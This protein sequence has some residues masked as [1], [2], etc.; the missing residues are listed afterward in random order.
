MNKLTEVLPYLLEASLCMLGFYVLYILLYRKQT[1]FKVNR[2]YL[3]VTLLASLVIPLIKIHPLLVAQVPPALI[4][5]VTAS[6]SSPI[7]EFN[8]VSTFNI[9]NVITII[10]LIGVGLGVLFYIYKLARLVSL[11]ASAKINIIGRYQV[12]LTE[13]KY[14]TSSF[15]NYILWDNKSGEFSELEMK[16][17]IAHEMVHIKQLHTV[18][19]LLVELVKCFF[20]FNPVA[21]L[22]NKELKMTHEFL[23][24]DDVVRKSKEFTMA[25][26]ERLLSKQLLNNVGYQLTNNFNMSN[27]KTRINMI[28]KPKSKKA[29]LL[30][31]FVAVPAMAFAILWVQEPVLA[32]NPNPVEIIN[33]QSIV[34]KGTYTGKKLYVQNPFKSDGSG[35]TTLEVR[36]NGEVFDTPSINSSAFEIDLS[37][38]YPAGT[39]V[40]IE[41]VHSKGSHPR[42]LNPEVIK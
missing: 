24:D 27:L 19:N 42:F 33:G 31:T 14:P 2:V 28:S 12:I 30:R 23:A 17:M 15:F 4:N 40:K 16:S 38:K 22:Y 29:A 41:L 25:D 7:I 10:Y 1:F 35:F 26:Y 11:I 34:L 6:S 18:D 39:D 13:G 20:W 9:W 21:Y 5:P 36:V 32:N 8:E 3:T 37:S